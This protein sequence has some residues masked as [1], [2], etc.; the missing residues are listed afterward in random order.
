MS[1]SEVDIYNFAL[2]NAGISVFVGNINEASEARRVCTRWYTQCRDQV[3][4]D[5]P[6]PFATKAVALSELSDTF[7]GWEFVYQYPSDCLRAGAVMTSDGMRATNGFALLFQ[8]NQVVPFPIR[9]PYSVALAADNSSQVILTDLEEA[10]LIYIARVTVVT[11]FQPDFV[12]ALSWKLA[13]R[14]A[15]P[16]QAKVDMALA[17]EKSYQFAIA[18]AWANAMNEATPDARPDSPS[19]AVR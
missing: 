14:I 5:F 11:V 16:L 17:A 4:R 9:T 15:L 10:W 6:W 2:S 12:D 1:S 19:I 13:S 7:P 18:N 8:D 3:L